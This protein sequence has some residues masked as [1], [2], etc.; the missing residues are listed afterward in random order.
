VVK[1]SRTSL[2]TTDRGWQIYLT[3]IPP[4]EKRVWLSMGNGLVV[5][6]R[7][8]GEKI[9][10]TR[11]RRRGE[12]NPRRVPIGSFPACS[13]I[14]ARRRLLELG[15]IVAE[16]RD[17]ALEQRRARAGVTTLRT[18][19]DFIRVYLDRRG[20]GQIGD[21]TLRLDRGLLE[22]VLAPALGDRLLVDLA[23]VDFGK[24]TSDY[25]AHL[26]REGRS[27]GTNANKFLAAVRRMYRKGRGWGFDI[28]A[29]DPTAG[30]TK[31]AKEIPRDRILFDGRVLV[32]PNA[33]VNEIGQ[34][35]SAL[36][37]E[38]SP[39]PVSR[40]TRLAL[41]LALLLGFRAAEV[42]SLEWRA[43]SLDGDAPS[44]S[45]TA[46]K[47]KAGLRTLPLPTAAAAIL[48]ELRSQS[49][50]GV[51]VFPGANGASAATR[52]A[53]HLHPESLSRGF[54]RACAR[55]GI[56]GASAH[57]LRRTCLSGLVELGHEGVAERIAGHAARDVLGRHY[58]RSRRLDAMRLA[59]TAWAGAVE[60]ARRR[61]EA[62]RA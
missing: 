45:V 25:A 4:P 31:P 33:T 15:S 48:A 60:D 18:L 23:P 3:N 26:R 38:P 21:K 56:D 55:L 12:K 54:S 20:D 34:L 1:R 62:Q 24:V 37:A 10:Q 30:L 32:G 41:M 5:E 29:H 2:P 28:P 22:R 52:R 39:V 57:D 42:S 17:P 50:K 16:G 19:N 6:L 49:G 44:V 59:L 27:N 14:D 43:V 47:T 35:G 53:E 11:P 8:S 51:Y 58:D 9:F 13:V 46:S 7:P 36:I 61:F 40:P